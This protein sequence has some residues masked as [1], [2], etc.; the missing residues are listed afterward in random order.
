MTDLI[1][2]RMREVHLPIPKIQARLAVHGEV[3]SEAEWN[4]IEVALYTSHPFTAK[5]AEAAALRFAAIHTSFAY[6]VEHNTFYR[7]YCETAGFLPG[8]LR[9]PDD[10]PHIP[11]VPEHLFKGC[12]GPEQFVTWLTSLSSDEIRWPSPETLGGSYDEQIVALHHNHGV[13]VRTTSG[14]SGVPSFLPRDPITRRR[15]A[16]WKIL[17]Y[18]AM[19]PTVLDLPDLLSIT[20]WPL[21]FSWANLITPQEQVYALL[22]KKLGL[23]TVIRAM[24]TTEPQG[25]LNRLLGRKGKGGGIALLTGLAA[26]LKELSASGAPGVLWAPPFLLYSLVRFICERELRFV[27]GERW[28]IELGG[29][30]KLLHEQPLSQAGLRTL[31]AQVLGVPPGQ[32]HD[33]YGSTEC[34]GLCGLSYEGELAVVIG[35]RAKDVPPEE[36]LNYVAGYTICNDVSGRDYQRRSGPGVGKSF[37]TFAPLG[38]AIVTR[39]EVPDLHVLDLRTLVSGEEMQHSNTRHL[40]FNLNYLIDYLSHIFGSLIFPVEDSISSGLSPPLAQTLDSL[41]DPGRYAGRDGPS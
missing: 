9:G 41:P 39:D 22:D 27:L 19:Y 30:W 35:K 31:A 3:P 14:S 26:R 4:P 10:L 32:I 12:Q 20:L 6:H 28:R 23:E 38:P 7:R 15:S 17:T 34:L 5:P 13:Q 11:L 25:I 8:D 1:R 18:F 37:D 33:I 2:A 24:T 29:G 40:I 36:A 21:D 16:H